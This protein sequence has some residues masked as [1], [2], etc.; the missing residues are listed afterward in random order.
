VKKVIPFR[1]N[2]KKKVRKPRTVRSRIPAICQTEEEEGMVT[3]KMKDGTWET[4]RGKNLELDVEYQ[5][6]VPCL[7]VKERR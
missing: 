2:G 5:E 6:G 3:V 7:V 1:T 4:I